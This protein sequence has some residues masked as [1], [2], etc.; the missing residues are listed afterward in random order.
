MREALASSQLPLPLFSRGKVRDNY[1]LGDKLLMVATDRVS[2]FDAVLPCAIPDKGRVLASLSAFWFEQT[3]AIVPNHLLRFIKDV[4][5]LKSYLPTRPGRAEPPS[6]LAGRT[7]VVKKAQRI[8]VECV[9]RGYLSGSA[10]EEYRQKGRVYGIALPPGLVE[11]QQLPHPLF[12]PTTKAAQGHDMPLTMSELN[13][14]VGADLAQKLAETAIKVY[15][16]A[17]QYAWER[18]I[19]IADTKM[20]FGFIEGQLCLIDE[21]LT[22]DSSRFWDRKRYQ[23]GQPQPSYDKQPLRDWLVAQGWNKEPPAPPLPPEI[24]AE[25]AA[26]YRRAHYLLTGRELEADC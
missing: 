4:Q 12:T 13:K 8:E 5:E 17:H 15:E 11:S 23:P 22:P 6:W 14:L 26:L 3:A 19:I 2:A 20:E 9:V 7:M 18:G 1:D 24:I 21:L 16:F 10:W 25:T